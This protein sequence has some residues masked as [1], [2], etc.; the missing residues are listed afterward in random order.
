[1]YCTES[2]ETSISTT[3]VWIYNNQEF[4]NYIFKGIFHVYSSRHLA[5]AHRCVHSFLIFAVKINIANIYLFFNE[6]SVFVAEFL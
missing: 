2:S 5:V 3:F 6:S 4:H 1:M